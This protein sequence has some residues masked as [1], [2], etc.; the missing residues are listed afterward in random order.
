MW[1]VR[2]CC[3]SG[4]SYL[5]TVLRLPR[6]TRETSDKKINDGDRGC[7][8][9]VQCRD[10][11]RWWDTTR[12]RCL[13]IKCGQLRIRRP[14][15][16]ALGIKSGE[17]G[18]PGSLAGFGVLSGSWPQNRVSQDQL[19]ETGCL[20]IN[21]QSPSKMGVSEDHFYIMGCSQ[22]HGPKTGC[23]RINSQRPLCPVDLRSY[24]WMGCE[25]GVNGM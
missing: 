5:R 4:F 12:E 23:L 3:R 8:R 20:R 11:R 14:S 19:P 2:P 25:W 22:D 24:L 10:A 6:V 13:R 1:L 17:W 16:G 18:V 9:V 15:L 21:F 7:S